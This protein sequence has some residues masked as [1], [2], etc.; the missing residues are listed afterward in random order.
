MPGCWPKMYSAW[1][2]VS[3]RAVSKANWAF[4]ETAEVAL[5]DVG[6]EAVAL[7]GVDGRR[8]LVNRAVIVG[9]AD[10]DLDVDVVEF[11]FKCHLADEVAPVVR[12]AF[13]AVAGKKAALHAEAF[14]RR[15]V[16][17]FDSQHDAEVAFLREERLEQVGTFRRFAFGGGVGDLVAERP[18][19]NAGPH[20]E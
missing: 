16:R 2:A 6:R 17:P 5:R 15:V 14:P 19:E 10:A 12:L 4:G 11:V 8:S 7:H 20:L 9:G 1:M 13:D 3:P 18:V